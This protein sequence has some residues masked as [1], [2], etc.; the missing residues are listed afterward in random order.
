MSALWGLPALFTIVL[1]HDVTRM[2]HRWLI[3]L[4]QAQH[5]GRF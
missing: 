2:T 5:R 1:Q 3:Q 4:L